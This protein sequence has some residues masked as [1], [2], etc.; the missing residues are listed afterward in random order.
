MKRGRSA[1]K[2]GDG[3]VKEEPPKKVQK[4][5]L[6]T[7]VSLQQNVASPTPSCTQ[8]K[9]PK[10]CSKLGSLS[11][12]G[13]QVPE[14]GFDSI[15]KLAENCCSD[16]RNMMLKIKEI[17]SSEEHVRNNEYY[18]SLITYKR[19]NLIPVS[20]GRWPFTNHELGTVISSIT[21]NNNKQQTINP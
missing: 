2:S 16:I 8:F 15:P 19:V 6:K 12:Y 21:K 13:E 4:K 7:P 14:D 3:N 17:K 10:S 18:I 11:M 1:S 20:L 9:P 5:R